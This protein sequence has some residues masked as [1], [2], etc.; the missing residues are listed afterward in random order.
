VHRCGHARALTRARPAR[1]GRREKRGYARY[2]RLRTALASAT[3]QD[4]TKKAGRA[5][6]KRVCASSRFRDMRDTAYAL[7]GVPHVPAAQQERVVLSILVKAPGD[8]RRMV[9]PGAAVAAVRAKHPGITV[10]WHETETEAA[11]VQLSWLARTSILVGNIGS[12]SFRLV[13]LPDGAQV[14]AFA[15]EDLVYRTRL[16]LL[17]VHVCAACHGYASERTRERGA[18]LRNWARVHAAACTRSSVLYDRPRGV[19]V[20]IAG[21]LEASVL[22]GDGR[23]RSFGA[24]RWFSE[25]SQCWDDLEYVLVHQYHVKN[26]EVVQFG[27]KR[28]AMGRPRDWEA[29][30]HEYATRT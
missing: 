13:F 15:L 2:V 17:A 10:E 29:V 9:V 24:G 11:A 16:R 27:P 20:I 23:T 18:Q 6:I 19:Q 3:N 8:K 21:A 1:A 30:R 26:D 14:R 4:W 22:G 25:S 5:R 7:H 12:N 28:H